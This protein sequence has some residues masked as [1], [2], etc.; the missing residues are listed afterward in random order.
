MSSSTYPVRE[1]ELTKRSECL[2]NSFQ[3]LNIIVR[4]SWFERVYTELLV[5]ES[6][7]CHAKVHTNDRN[8]VKLVS[9]HQ[10]KEGVVAFSRAV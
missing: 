3:C 10:V 1:V 7:I 4:S 8:Y 6:Q 5:I 9:K 2:V